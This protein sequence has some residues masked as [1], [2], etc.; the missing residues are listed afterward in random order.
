MTATDDDIHG[1]LESLKRLILD[2]VRAEQ[3]RDQLTTLPNG[4]ALNAHIRERLSSKGDV[5]PFW[6]AFIEVDRFK[7]V[8]DKFGYEHADALLKK[9]AETLQMACSWFEATTLAYRAHGDE[10]YLMGD[11]PASGQT[12]IQSSLDGVRNAIGRISLPVENR[13]DLMR[14]T[15]SVGWLTAE[16]IRTL[17]TDRTIMAALETAAAE[18]K[19][20]RNTVVRYSSDLV[21]EPS[22]SLRGDCAA[23]G[24]KFSFEVKRKENREADLVACPNC[25]GDVPRPPTPSLAPPVTPVTV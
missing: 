5:D 19:R 18:A 11:V 7:S 2:R 21:A 25:R 9:I 22:I 12:L 16:D 14:C 20:T 13:S 4:A 8:N 17:L 24:T 1:A 6:V 10:F 15:V 3:L 23:C